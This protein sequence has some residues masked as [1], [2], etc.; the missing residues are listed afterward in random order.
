MSN[1]GSSLCSVEQRMPTAGW[2]SMRIPSFTQKSF[3]IPRCRIFGHELVQWYRQKCI[4][5]GVVCDTEFY[6][7]IVGA[8]VIEHEIPGVP[9]SQSNC[10]SPYYQGSLFIRETKEGSIRR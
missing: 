7:V 6:K 9:P 5:D 8:I 2:V 3:T 1:I 4:L 10:I